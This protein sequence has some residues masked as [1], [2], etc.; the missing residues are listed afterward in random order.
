MRNAVVIKGNKSGMTVFLDPELPFDELLT[1]IATKFQE[2]SRF[3]GSVQMTLTLEGREL[4]PEEEFQ[5]V[6]VITEHSQIEILCL[7]DR[8]ANRMKQCEKALNEKLMELS[9][10]TGQ[11]FRG[12]LQRGEMLESET[13]I[14]IIGD[15]C[16]GAKVTAKG[17]V[18]IL[19]ELNGSATAGIAGNK[20]AV[21]VAF[22]MAPV[23]IRIC[24]HSSK[25]QQK[26]KKLG[27]GPMMA[28]LEDDS[29]C[30]KNIKKS[31]FPMLKSI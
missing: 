31:F 21:I 10:T 14:V 11:F 4:T 17:N 27:K 16:Q 23:Q 28:Y 2:S 12:N 25:F 8:D 13:S 18:V 26:G 15:V 9:L 7:I 1:C 6:N 24:D 5:I 30:I 29:L 22:N 3:W 19:G 20:H